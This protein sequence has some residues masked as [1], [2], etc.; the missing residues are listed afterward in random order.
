[1]PWREPARPHRGANAMCDTC[2]EIDDRIERYRRILKNVSDQEFKERAEA[3]IARMAAKKLALNSINE[4][5]Q[6]APKQ[7]LQFA[8]GT[9][10]GHRGM[11]AGLPRNL[12]G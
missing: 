5:D 9:V 4:K 12:A 1:M 7:V 10:E 3:L 11:L 8:W 2:D 6:G